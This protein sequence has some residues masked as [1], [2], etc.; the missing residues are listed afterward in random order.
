MAERVELV[1][2]TDASLD[3]SDAV[4]IRATSKTGILPPGNVSKTL[5][6]KISLRHIDHCKCCK[7]SWTDNCCRSIMYT[8]AQFTPSAKHDKTALSVSCQAV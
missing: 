4:L 7:L 6:F 8:N 2:D 5:D 3:L 1:L